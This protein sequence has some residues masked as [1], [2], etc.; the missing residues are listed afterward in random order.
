MSLSKLPDSF[1]MCLSKLCVD[2]CTF[3]N[4][5][6]SRTVLGS[7]L[8]DLVLLDHQRRL[9]CHAAS[10]GLNLLELA[11]VEAEDVAGLGLVQRRVVERQ[12]DTR[13]EGLVDGADSVDRDKSI[14][15]HVLLGS[16]S[17]EHI[18]L[19]EQKDTVP[20]MRE[21]EDVLESALNGV[22]GETEITASN[23]KQ[24]LAVLHGDSL[25]CSSLTNTRN[26]VKK[27]HETSALSLDQILARPLGSNICIL[28]LKNLSL[29]MRH[30]QAADNILV[31]ALDAEVLKDTRL[32]SHGLEKVEVDGQ[33]A[34]L[35]QGVCEH[36]LGEKDKVLVA[37]LKSLGVGLKGSASLDT[38][39][40]ES[41]NSEVV[42]ALSGL[43]TISVLDDLVLR[44]SHGVACAVEPVLDGHLVILDLASRRL[45]DGEPVEARS[46]VGHLLDLILGVGALRRRVPGQCPCTIL[47]VAVIDVVHKLSAL[48]LESLEQL[49]VV[50]T[51]ANREDFEGL[52]RS[53]SNEGLNLKGAAHGTKV[54][55]VVIDVVSRDLELGVLI[56]LLLIGEEV[57]AGCGI[58]GLGLWAAGPVHAPHL[59]VSTAGLA[60]GRHVDEVAV[61]E[62]GPEIVKLDAVD[63]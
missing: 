21:T 28:A 29:E 60:R 16:L 32:T 11:N 25:C 61:A 56:D 53:L 39:S 24:R 31:I 14:T 8:D 33:E 12:V 19:V 50:V 49:F 44:V 4:Q 1:F 27:D 3:S 6:L 46:P 51:V 40:K 10:L 47:L 18:S 42:P 2:I 17:Q 43:N 54:V 37:E 52:D 36:A 22:R 34:T 63:G 15:L 48:V 55:S 59:V 35:T 5:V 9:A 41:V 57:P 20:E 7:E 45:V 38:S 13:L 26:T 62:E 23:D 58:R 30:D